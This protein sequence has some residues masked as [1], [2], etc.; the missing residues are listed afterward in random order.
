MEI[1]TGTLASST[2]CH[3]NAGS[4]EV[5]TCLSSDNNASLSTS[6]HRA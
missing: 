5:F 2:V 1:S 3:K 4:V 6:L